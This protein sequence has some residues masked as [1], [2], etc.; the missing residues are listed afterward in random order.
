VGIIAQENHMKKLLLILF[1][2][3]LLTVTLKAAQPKKVTKA[4]VVLRH[5]RIYT[6]DA[7]RSWARSIAIKDGKI[8]YVGDD[9]S[10][11]SL[12]DEKTS[13]IELDNK[14]VLPGFI[15]SHVHPIE[16]GIGMERCDL[17]KEENK[18]AV[19]K[20]IKECSEAGP[21]SEWLLGSGWALPVFPA[22]NPQKE[23][24]DEIVK[25]RPA[26]L[27]A[28]DGHS[29]WANSKAL[30]VSG[31]TKDTPDPTDGR[32]E[33]NAQGEPTG[34]LRES[35]VE[36]VQKHAPAPT[37]EQSLIGLQK[38]IGEMNHFGIT[39][40]QDAIVTAETLPG[41]YIIRDGIATYKEGEKRGLL[42]ARVTGALLADPKGDLNKIL[43]QV[44]AFKKLREEYRGENFYPTSIKIFEDGVIEANTAALLHPYLD[45]GND[46]GKLVWEPEKLN[47]FVE[48][49]DKEKFQI[50]FHAIGDRAVR[51]AL[52]ALESARRNNG[53]RDARPLLA[54]IELIDPAD[55]SRFARIGAIPCFQPLWAY[56]DAYITD[57][58]RPKLGDDR[59]RWIY[60]IESMARTG[61]N[62][63]F[64]SDWNVS[65]VNPLDGIEVAV[66]RSSFEGAQAGKNVF[67]PEERIDLPTALAA[68]TIGGAFANFWEKETGSLE[69][70]K[71]A[72][73]IV[74]DKNLF[75][76]PPSELSEVRVL[77]TLFKGK[78]VYRDPLWR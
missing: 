40:Y 39:G 20:K 35:A 45:K 68:Y 67:I 24:L 7:S 30:E 12:I 26:L 42:S 63:A 1:A 17:T 66:T 33:R 29:A 6:M 53:P 27:I 3:I 2:L 44:A 77:L 60:P 43:D 21:N 55:V 13:T 5:G 31:I 4:D 71:S 25:D 78:T 74:L 34:T 15:D 57:L 23:W 41:E 50:H 76:I 61:A 10:I 56:E 72:E 62:M 18:D 65:S 64:G 49:L 22:A 9:A 14:F 36:L 59:M 70:G 16:A 28:A 69:V 54:H 37:L 75:E 58:T 48:L 38:A 11:T 73:V 32:F 19:L 46:A 47:P 8:I 51:I 52:N